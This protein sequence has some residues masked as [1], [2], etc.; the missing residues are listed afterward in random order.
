V[1]YP[2]LSPPTST[3]AI[4][5]P[6]TGSSASVAATLA[7]GIYSSNNDFLNGAAEQVAYTYKRLGGDI[8]DIELTAGQVYNAYEEAVLEYS[9]L[10]NIHQAKNI[11]G[12]VL[13]STTASFDDHGEVSGSGSSVSLLFPHITFGYAKQIADGFSVE[14]QVGGTVTE[15]SASVPVVDG[16]QDYDLQA[17]LKSQSDAG[18][19]DY[20][21]L[22]TNKKVLIRRV[23]YKTARATWRFYGYY[24]GLNV[25][26]NLTTY[27]Q[28]ADDSTFEIIPTWQNKLQA[29][30]YQDSLYTRLS[31]Y[32]Y[33]IR[34]NKLRLYPIPFVS[35]IENFWVRFII[36]KD[37]FEDTADRQ[38]GLQGI[39]N[40]NTLPIANVP[41]ENINA[42]G[43][44]WIR[45]FALALSKEILGHTRGKFTSIPIPGNDLTLNAESLLAQ[46]K[47]EQE[48]LREELKTVLD[49]LTYT[50]LAETDAQRAEYVQNTLSR[51]PLPIYKG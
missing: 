2:N 6:V 12:G 46:A 22:I 5:L 11:L 44:Q 37:P 51:M 29:L 39:N 15:Y 42:I 17:I 30:A 43:K 41:Y 25:V 16:Q 10:V 34:N 7:F 40:M 14:A 8:L 1:A 9:Y 28:F 19:V 38:T 47:D 24:G 36:P 32:S 50:K 49:E 21:N 48:K 23:F 3:S 31:H 20:A 18:G 33:E 13:G 27:G 26:G 4:V 45:R 35:N